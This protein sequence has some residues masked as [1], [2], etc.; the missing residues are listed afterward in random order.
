M[1]LRLPWLWMARI[2]QICSK[3]G[4]DVGYWDGLS[5][6]GHCL[7][8]LGATDVARSSVVDVVVF[9]VQRRRTVW[10]QEFLLYVSEMEALFSST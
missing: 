2:V 3:L 4:G 1:V 10:T 9:E 6:R 8:W 7:L 5:I